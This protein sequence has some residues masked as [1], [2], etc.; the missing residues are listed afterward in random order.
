MQLPFETDA[1]KSYQSAGLD[2]SDVKL[3]QHF[4]AVKPSLFHS[5]DS[6]F[7]DQPASDEWSEKA[8][9]AGSK[10]SAKTKDVKVLTPSKEEI[11]FATHM[12]EFAKHLRIL[13]DLRR[14]WTSAGKRRSRRSRLAD[15]LQYEYHP[16]I[17][18]LIA[19]L[20]KRRSYPGWRAGLWPQ[21]HVQGS[22]TSSIRFRWSFLNE[23]DLA[24]G[25]FEFFRW[26]Q[27]RI[28][29]EASE[30]PFRDIRS[31]ARQFIEG[32]RVFCASS[33]VQQYFLRRLNSSK[34]VYGKTVDYALRIVRQRSRCHMAVVELRVDGA[35]WD[36]ETIREVADVAGALVSYCA[37][38]RK[39]EGLIGHA[40]RLDTVKGDRQK[41]AWRLRWL[42]FVEDV[43]GR[44]TISAEELGSTLY[45]RSV[46]FACT[47]V[48]F[49]SRTWRV[50]QRMCHVG[51]QK[52]ETADGV[53]ETEQSNCVDV[54]AQLI[55]EWVADLTKA[56]LYRR[57]RI[58]QGIRPKM[59][60]RG[61]AADGRVAK[62]KPVPWR[63]GGD[64]QLRYLWSTEQLTCI[65]IGDRLGRSE[66]EIID[67]LVRLDIC[68][69]HAE[70]YEDGLQCVRK[71]RRNG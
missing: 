65:Q 58:M 71:R 18:V 20:L 33:E 54:P 8:K 62:K 49:D 16:Y 45:V 43:N 31:K 48:F 11:E 52:S 26:W 19:F 36:D 56:D 61:H 9:P 7:P 41:A 3:Y 51:V 4:L 39:S 46:G 38:V 12:L 5:S 59:Y 21:S 10:A 69:S 44:P 24:L 30:G 17:E 55:N 29:P 14:S 67:R 22:R 13:M 35:R 1:Y 66:E 15:L 28:P 47:K 40:W 63:K 37:K 70:A 50:V 23:V 64:D 60:G 42:V 6:L 32:L 57:I 25:D 68:R 2:S 53:T 34:N 27:L